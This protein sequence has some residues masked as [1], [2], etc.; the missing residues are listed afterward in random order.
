MTTHLQRTWNIPSLLHKVSQLSSIHPTYFIYIFFYNHRYLFL[1]ELMRCWKHIVQPVRT[2]DRLPRW[3]CALQCRKRLMTCPVS[4][5]VFLLLLI[6]YYDGRLRQSL[7][8]AAVYPFCS[9]KQ[10]WTWTCEL[11]VEDSQWAIDV[12]LVLFFFFCWY[13]TFFQLRYCPNL[14]CSGSP[15]AG[16]SSLW[17]SGS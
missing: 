13:A 14:M 6:F 1:G 3:S 4:S 7:V 12:P 10:P 8:Y 5:D 11:D 17:T 15:A 16:G 9:L 2:T